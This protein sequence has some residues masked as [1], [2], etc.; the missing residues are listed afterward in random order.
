MQSGS[1][2]RDIMEQYNS[3]GYCIV[4]GNMDDLNLLEDYLSGLDIP[5]KTK[6]I[7]SLLTFGEAINIEIS[8]KVTSY[9]EKNLREFKHKRFLT[10]S[11]LIKPARTSSE[12]FLHQDWTYAFLA[13][14]QPVTCWAPLID[15][16]ADSGGMFILSGS[17]KKSKAYHSNSYPT[18]RFSLAEIGETNITFV[19][20]KRGEILLFNPLVW[21][22]SS[23]NLSNKPRAVVTCLMHAEEKH[24]LYFH[25]A[26]QHI[27]NVYELPEYGLERFLP[28]LVNDILPQPVQL[29]HTISYEHHLPSADELIQSI[30]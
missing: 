25:K 21:H 20:L 5:D 26:D 16:D 12:L 6:F 18:S 9:F 22:G 23:R 27:C 4:Q 14:E 10:G 13:A 11:F 28:D 30:L 1:S 19:E 29:V 24:L 3:C 2:E 17:H 15:T 8:Q 7:Y